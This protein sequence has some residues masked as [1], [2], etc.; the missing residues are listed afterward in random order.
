MNLSDSLCEYSQPS[1]DTG[2]D[3]I[4]FCFS[5]RKS[6]TT[7]GW[8][9]MKWHQQQVILDTFFSQWSAIQIHTHTCTR[10]HTRTHTHRIWGEL[11]KSRLTVQQEVKGK[12]QTWASS[13]LLLTDSSS[14]SSLTG[15]HTCLNPTEGRYSGWWSGLPSHWPG[16]RPLQGAST[17]TMTDS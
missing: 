12:P 17:H 15:P 11:C 3:T 16:W 4:I 2:I 14:R 9:D 13:P 1:F 8:V 6:M 5:K 10:L 7:S